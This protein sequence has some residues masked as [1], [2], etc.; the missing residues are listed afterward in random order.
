MIESGCGLRFALEAG[1]GAG[2]VADIFGEKFQRDV[3]MEAGVFGFVD[4]AHAA[5]AEAFEDAIVREGLA[6]ELVGAW[7]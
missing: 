4:D 7:T 3:A 5:G 1:E 6:D 2:V